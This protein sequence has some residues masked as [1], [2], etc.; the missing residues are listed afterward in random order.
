MRSDGKGS[1]ST[2]TRVGVEAAG[3][4]GDEQERALHHQDKVP[5]IDSTIADRSCCAIGPTGSS[6][7]I[8]ADGREGEPVGRLG[9]ERVGEKFRG[10][11]GRTAARGGEIIQFAKPLHEVVGEIESAIISAGSEQGGPFGIALLV[12]HN[13]GSQPLR[14]PP[15]PG[16]TTVGYQ[17]GL[18]RFESMVRGSKRAC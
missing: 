1:T 8:L 7:L 17:R 18:Q 14:V 5:G 10:S 11:H 12:E 3:R 16:A 15:T 13:R 6:R 2:T 9:P 4:Q